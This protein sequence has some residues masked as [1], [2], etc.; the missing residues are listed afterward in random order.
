MD[1]PN[2]PRRPRGEFSDVHEGN[3]SGVFTLK[4][5]AAG[6]NLVAFSASSPETTCQRTPLSRI[7]VRTHKRS[8]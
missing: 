3:S 4:E 7:Q 5:P 8:L 6:I 2:V 1:S